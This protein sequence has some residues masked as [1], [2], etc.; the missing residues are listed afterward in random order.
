MSEWEEKSQ[1]VE[2]KINK[3]RREGEKR[4]EK[5]MTAFQWEKLT[6]QSEEHV[7]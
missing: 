5:R 1:K 3:E 2:K 6:V 7:F 4:E